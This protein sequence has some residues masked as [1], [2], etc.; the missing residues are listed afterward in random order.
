M[1]SWTWHCQG[2]QPGR[3]TYSDELPH[4]RVCSFSHLFPN[5]DC[6]KAISMLTKLLSLKEKSP[7]RDSAGKRRLQKK[8][9]TV[10]K[11]AMWYW[12]IPHCHNPQ[13]STSSW[14]LH[15]E[16]RSEFSSC[17]CFNLQ[18]VNSFYEKQLLYRRGLC[19]IIN[20]SSS[21]STEDEMALTL[22]IPMMS[23]GQVEAYWWIHNKFIHSHAFIFDIIVLT[24]N[25]QSPWEV[26]HTVVPYSN[27][28]TLSTLQALEF[29]NSNLLAVMNRF[30][31]TG[32]LMGRMDW[33]QFT[34]NIRYSYCLAFCIL[35]LGKKL[36]QALSQ[37][38]LVLFTWPAP[39]F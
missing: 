33:M 38:C 27:Q 23:G 20:V 18:Q 15:L 1:T 24:F 35:P 32:I 19:I 16:S 26:T 9:R 13:T 12:I 10:H 2:K 11:F 30:I 4:A 28:S 8:T 34:L 14:F 21:V 6:Y 29:Q 7:R 22:G 5:S 37:N 31:S 25:S 17:K 3:E 39:L 36:D